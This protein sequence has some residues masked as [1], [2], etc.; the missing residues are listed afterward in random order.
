MIRQDLHNEDDL[1]VEF[2]LDEDDDVDRGEHAP[3]TRHLDQNRRQPRRHVPPRRAHEAPAPLADGGL[4]NAEPRGDLAIGMALRAR[5]DDASAKRQLLRR[6]PSAHEAL[7][8]L[9]LL[10]AELERNQAPADSRHVSPHHDLQGETFGRAK[11][12]QRTSDSG[13]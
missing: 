1:H 6:L 5:Q 2:V 4:V 9:T 11:L 3:G 10:F 7:E 13:H 8:R 12:F